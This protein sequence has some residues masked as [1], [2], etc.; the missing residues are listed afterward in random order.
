MTAVQLMDMAT[1]V[2]VLVLLVFL[3]CRLRFFA[4]GGVTGRYF[5]LT[6]GLIVLLASC[7][8]W[9]RLSPE[10][11]T[12]FI[13][14]VYRAVDLAQ[15]GVL[16]VGTLLLAIGLAL[17]ADY[18]QT[19]RENIESRENKLSVLEN[20]QRDAREPY[21]LMELLSIGL[22]ETL[23]ALPGCAG[24]VFLINRRRRQFV[25][26]ASAALNKQE[27]AH[28]EYYPLDRNV[29]AQA[30]EL[31]EPMMSGGFSFVDRERRP[32]DSRF[33][34]ALVLPLVSG[35]EQIGAILL[36]AEEPKFFSRS[37]IR[38]L[39]PVAEWLAEKVKS[40]RL[41]RE[42]S[43]ARKQVELYRSSQADLASRLKAASEAF[44]AA[45]AVV[46]FSR[47]LV[48][49]ATAESV[50]LYGL[51]NGSLH[52]FGGSEPLFDLS[53]SYKTALIDAVD[54][55][56]PLIV[57][58]EG[59][60]DEGRTSIV[61]SSLIVPFE[62]PE[63][64]A[65]LLL[66]RDA[67]PFK[68][69]EWELRALAT[70]TNLAA[71]LLSRYESERLAISRRLGFDKVLELIHPEPEQDF[72]ST[73][74]YFL[75]HLA[76]VLPEGSMGMVFAVSPGDNFELVHARG[77]AENERAKAAFTTEDGALSL[78]AKSRQVRIV[79]GRKA[80]ASDLMH[81]E[82]AAAGSL[83][84][85]FGEKGVPT[86]AVYCP[87]GALE[88][89]LGVVA[90]FMYSVSERERGEW[91]RLL[92]L[93]SGLYSLRLAIGELHETSSAVRTSPV[94]SPPVMDDPA[95]LVNRLNN[96]LSAIIGHAQLTAEGEPEHSPVRQSLRKVIE[97][98]ER[99]GDV[100]RKALVVPAVEQTTE[101]ERP[102][103][104][105][106]VVI[107]RVLARANISG[108]LHLVGGRAHPVNLDLQPV[109]QP[110][111]VGEHIQTLFE[112]VL[113]RFGALAADEDVINIATYEMGGYV[114]LDICRHGRNF[115]PVKAVATFGTYD[116][117]PDALRNHP[118]DVFLRHLDEGEGYFSADRDAPSPTYLSFKF[119]LEAKGSG[120][121]KVP[122]S[123]VRVL[124]I[125]DEAI[126]LDL[127]SAMCHSMGY[128][129]ETARSGEEGLKL[130]ATG[131]FDVVL[132]DLSMPGMSGLAV[133]RE[134]RKSHPNIPIILVTGWGRNLEP[135]DIASAGIT[136]VLYKPFRIEQLTEVVRSAALSGR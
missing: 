25:L 73:P 104:D 34:S 2:L 135:D 127:I 44:G 68:V 30:V 123:S 59:T 21:P 96:H 125:D 38:L 61:L 81:Y 16:A 6:G 111:L 60:D 75:D 66:R 4:E 37:D 130:A 93:A 27:T 14:S 62:R 77:L 108:D 119:P 7:W 55:D 72:A 19:R 20:L 115:P 105:L 101:P 15:F 92:T 76:E 126:I 8:Q 134:I 78:A 122:A 17:Y 49:F 31:G 3:V 33:N 5:F 29:V 50:H 110:T 85:K 91:E 43:Q 94:G 90:I 1:P 47:G 79:T 10:Y 132:T 97:E 46:E 64:R 13:P 88:R 114:F 51:Q 18:W 63:G 129:V 39:S 12:W 113:D 106:N 102:V 9:V 117:A 41:S 131:R 84:R 89:T 83:V 80:V 82:G 52:V 136:D 116:A 36:L 11:S 95:P 35:M 109:G 86:F 99:A 42:F 32:V 54:R 103:S 65:A 22:K 87:F 71:L 23:Y 128:Q 124:A 28:L 112:A 98:A 48:G 69:E 58:Q 74:G 53:E 56:K 133:A 26:T 120:E 24:A 67:S 70:F 57:N 100:I 45:D 107:R 40:A 121:E 118:A